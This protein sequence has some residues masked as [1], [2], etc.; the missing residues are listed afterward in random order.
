MTTS[1]HAAEVGS[2]QHASISSSNG[3]ARRPSGI[4]SGGG[5]GSG[6]IWTGSVPAPRWVR[7]VGMGLWDYLRNA[8]TIQKTLQQAGS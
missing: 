2:G 3:A 1:C 5:G 7:R 8:E 6:W 4:S